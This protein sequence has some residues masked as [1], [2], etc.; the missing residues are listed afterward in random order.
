MRNVP[1]GNVI[2]LYGV[3]DVVFVIGHSFVD[4][5]DVLAFAMM[6]KAHARASPAIR[7]HSGDMNIALAVCV[8]PFEADVEVVLEVD[9]RKLKRLTPVLALLGLGMTHR[10]HVY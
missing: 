6:S 2:S 1:P 8:R 5:R 3:F 4:A 7:G 10:I 9:A